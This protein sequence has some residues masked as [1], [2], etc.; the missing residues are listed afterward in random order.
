MATATEYDTVV[1]KSKEAAAKAK[2]AASTLVDKSKDA[3]GAF[4]G[5]AKEAAHSLGEMATE[6]AHVAGRKADELVGDAGAGMKKLGE[7]I[8]EKA[9]RQGVLGAASQ[10]FAKSVREGGEYIEHARL[11]GMAE[12]LTEI[13][14][15]NPFPSILVGI[16][17][18]FLLGRALRS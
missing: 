1:E 11:S 18:G 4:A 16:G 5:K 15:R 8:A 10:S 7:T 9:P 14:R 6:A 13:I 2:D 12:D 3:A 17:L